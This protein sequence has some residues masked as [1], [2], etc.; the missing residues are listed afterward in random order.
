MDTERVLLAV[1]LGRQLKVFISS[2]ENS[3][4]M[5]IFWNLTPLICGRIAQYGFCPPYILSF[6]LKK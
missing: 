6:F 4:K 1:L 2:T 5:S 3:S